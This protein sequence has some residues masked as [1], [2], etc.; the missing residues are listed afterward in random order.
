ME[1]KH[2]P[3]PWECVDSMSVRGPY[4]MGDTVSPGYLV[5]ALPTSTPPDERRANARL[6]ASAPDLL[7][8]A[9]KVLAWYEAEKDHSKEPD[10]YKRMDMCRDSEEAIR[11]AIAKATGEA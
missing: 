10:F 9:Q 5:A 8:A 6:I 4:F 7:E 1:A 2:T 3:A 11:S